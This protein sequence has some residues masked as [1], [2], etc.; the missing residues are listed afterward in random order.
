MSLRRLGII[1][2]G[3]IADLVLTT[4]AQTLAQPLEHVA[5]LA[6]PRSVGKA[7]AI[8]DRLGDTLAASRTVHSNAADLHCRQA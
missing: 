7:Q 4:L 2:S 6:S 1:G 3:G 8:L 5:I